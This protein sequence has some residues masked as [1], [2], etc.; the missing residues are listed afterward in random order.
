LIKELWFKVKSIDTPLRVKIV[1]VLAGIYLLNPIDLIPDFI[2]V[3]GQLDDIVVLSLAV[4]Y[5]KRHTDFDVR[6]TLWER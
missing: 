5:V 6:K 2:P 1:I 3:L 4:R